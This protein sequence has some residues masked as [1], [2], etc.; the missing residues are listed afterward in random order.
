MLGELRAPFANVAPDKAPSV[1][2]SADHGEGL[3]EL[4][5]VFHSTDLYDSQTHVPLV[6]TGPGIKPQHITETVRLTDLT[7]SLLELAGFA[8]PPGFDGTSFAGLTAG[9][10]AQK[11]DGG[12]A[13]SALTRDRSIPCGWTSAVLGPYKL[14][15]TPSGLERYNVR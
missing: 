3:G 10:R 13:Y 5:Q 9:T 4:G 7:P 11:L 8:V 14:L 1:S 15:D 6:I 12:S 2:I